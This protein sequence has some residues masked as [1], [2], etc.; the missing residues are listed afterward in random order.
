MPPLQYSWREET[1]SILSAGTGHPGQDRDTD[2]YD[3][4]DRHVDGANSR[5][6]KDPRYAA[7]YKSKTDE[8]NYQ[9]HEV[10][11]WLNPAFF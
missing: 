1:G 2:K 8:I 9:G 5:E 4:R 11:S 6:N 10:V 7:N 3:D